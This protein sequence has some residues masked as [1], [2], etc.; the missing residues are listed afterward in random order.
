MLGNIVHEILHALGFH[1]EHTRSDRDQY[2]TVLNQNIME[3]KERN[4]NKQS[5]E[6]FGLEYNAES[7]MHYG[8][9]SQKDW[10]KL[11][12][13][14]HWRAPQHRGASTYLNKNERHTPYLSFY[15]FQTDHTYLYVPHCQK[16]WLLNA[17]TPF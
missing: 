17:N 13:S 12:V 10:R 8:G 6:T 4:F 14:S 9:S 15:C 7:I 3:G 1:H 2:I 5:G 16:G 11:N